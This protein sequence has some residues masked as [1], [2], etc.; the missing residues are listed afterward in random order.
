MK[1]GEAGVARDESAPF[2]PKVLA[3]V[4][5]LQPSLQLGLEG[6]R[7]A[8]AGTSPDLQRG[9]RRVEVHGAPP[10]EWHLRHVEDVVAAVHTDAERV[11]AAQ[12]P[13]DHAG[14][15]AAAPG[16]R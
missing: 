4:G 11:V 5:P 2:V 10:S 8:V 12:V 13:P 14:A 9:R 1:Y 7:L 6:D 15:V 16:P 3:S